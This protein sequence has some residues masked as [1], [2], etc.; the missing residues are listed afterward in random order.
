MGMEMNRQN[1]LELYQLAVM[2]TRCYGLELWELL[3]EISEKYKKIQTERTSVIPTIQ[4]V[5]DGKDYTQKIQTRRFW[6]CVTVE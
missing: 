3:E 5:P 1:L 6:N 4:D 2:Y